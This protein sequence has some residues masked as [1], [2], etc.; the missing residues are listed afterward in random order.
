MI[1]KNKLGQRSNQLMNGDIYK[2]QSRLYGKNNK[3]IQR[4]NPKLNI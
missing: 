1:N 3:F 2:S 4:F